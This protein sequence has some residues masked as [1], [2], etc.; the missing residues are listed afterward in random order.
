MIVH[1]DLGFIGLALQS[2][3]PMS[4]GIEPDTRGH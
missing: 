2:D 3:S 1:G 4:F